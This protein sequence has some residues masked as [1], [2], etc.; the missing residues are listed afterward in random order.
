M[1]CYAGENCVH[2]ETNNCGWY[3]SSEQIAVA[4]ARVERWKATNERKKYRTRSSDRLQRAAVEQCE[5]TM[6]WMVMEEAEEDE[7]RAKE[8]ILEEARDQ[9]L[10]EVPNNGVICSQESALTT[11]TVSRKTQEDRETTKEG[12]EVKRPTR[13]CRPTWKKAQTDGQKKMKESTEFNACRGCG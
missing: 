4:K 3:H 7:R 12:E 1:P 9:A 5:S 13:K 11:C 2:L 10:F 6:E 8:R